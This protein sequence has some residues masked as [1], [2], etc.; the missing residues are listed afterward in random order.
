VSQLKKV[1]PLAYNGKH[2]TVMANDII[3]GK[4]EMTL[5]QAR[6]LRL[7]ITQVVK[8]DNDFKTYFCKIKDFATF[9]G[10]SKNNLYRDVREICRQLL[11][12][13][14][15]IG[16][17]NPKEPWKTFQWVQLAQYDGNGTIKLMLSEQ[18]KPYVLELDKWFTQ[19]QLVNILSLQSF[20]AIRLY[21]LIKCQDGINREEKEYLE[22]TI[23]Y[24]RQY[25][26]CENKFKRI[27]DFK[28]YVI[29][30]SIREINLKTDI[31]LITEY[32]KTGRTITSVRFY[33][34]CNPHQLNNKSLNSLGG[35]SDK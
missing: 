30:L 33:I 21:E 9:L 15:D 26:C 4:Q 6:L 18:I 14:V 1:Y 11:K 34:H 32:I 22:F 7:L 19:Y 27:S 28:R 17:G 12:L 16:S 10:I 3:K 24:L 20:Y 31:L 8:E 13:T 35:D 25:F 2:Y 5:Q 29:E 23:D